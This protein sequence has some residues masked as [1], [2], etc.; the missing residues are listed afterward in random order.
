M[1]FNVL[2]KMKI[3]LRIYDLKSDLHQKFGEGQQDFAFRLFLKNE[4]I[5]TQ[6]K[7]MLGIALV[8]PADLEKPL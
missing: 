8:F 7:T 5:F 3:V 2:E 4:F 6:N 1:D